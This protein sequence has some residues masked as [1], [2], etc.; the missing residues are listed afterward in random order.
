MLEA[1]TRY[2][3]SIANWDIGHTVEPMLI[4]SRQ[5]PDGEHTDQAVLVY[6]NSHG[7]LRLTEALLVNF[8]R[9]VRQLRHS[10]EVDGEMVS[11]EVIRDL[12]DWAAGLRWND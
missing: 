5:R 3:C 11:R 8:R 12:A 6:D 4:A 10:V 7:S 2:D 9:Y 1:I